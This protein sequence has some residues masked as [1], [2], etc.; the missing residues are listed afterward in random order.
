MERLTKTEC[1]NV[2]K[3]MIASS[4][5]SFDAF[6]LDDVHF[7]DEK[8][9]DLI[10]YEIQIQCKKIIVEMAKKLNTQID[11]NSCEDIVRTMYFE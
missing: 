10:L 8:S 6:A 11:Y 5:L 3:I 7:I 2:A 4:G 1:K 9:K